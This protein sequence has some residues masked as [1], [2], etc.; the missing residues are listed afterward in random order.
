MCGKLSKAM[1]GTRIAAKMWKREAGNT[2]KSAGFTAG[3]TSPCLF[4][5]PARDMMVF[6]HGDDFVSSGSVEDLKL[7][8]KVLSAKYSIKTTTIGEGEKLAK[9]V[10]ILNRIVRWRPGEGVTIEADPGHLEIL[11]DS[12]GV[13]DE[14]PLTTNGSKDDQE[15]EARRDLAKGE[16]L[17]DN[18]VSK[19]RSDVA[20][21]NYSAA[22]RRLVRYL[23]FRPRAVAWYK[24][25]EHPGCLQAYTDS[26]LAGRRETRKSTSGGCVMYGS[27]Y[28]KGWSKTQATRAL[29]LAEAELYSVVKTAGETIGIVSIFQD[30]NTIVKGRV[31]CDASAALGIVRRRGCWED[32]TCRHWFVVDSGEK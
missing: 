24:Y 6:S 2:L 27:H 7:L 28:L 19:Y 17:D 5:H 16:K 12:T 31:L 25:Q 11:V 13:K 21:L 32:K 30:F 26:D 23:K 29:S 18:S 22:V 9:E 4:H 1:Y 8:E 20:R 15:K 10:R 14:R 3:R